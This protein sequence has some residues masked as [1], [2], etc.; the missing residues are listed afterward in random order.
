MT[1]SFDAAALT[2]ALYDG[3]S[4]TRLTGHAK[5]QGNFDFYF[6]SSHCFEQGVMMAVGRRERTDTSQ[7]LGYLSDESDF[8]G[9]LPEIQFMTTRLITVR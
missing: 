2:R 8:Y 7:D 9:E 5:G 6:T 4:L 3:R 1:I